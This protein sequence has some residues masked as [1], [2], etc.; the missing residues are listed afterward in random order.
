MFRNGMWIAGSLVALFVAG[1]ALTAVYAADSADGKAKVG[2]P[3]PDFTLQDQDGKDVKLSSFF[4]GEDKQQKKIVVLE[5]FNP[6]CPFVVRHYEKNTM[7]DLAAKYA[8]QGVVWIAINSTHGMG[9]ER[10]QSWIDEHE[11]PY[12]FLHDQESAVARL[13]GAKTTPHM[14]VIDRNGV[15]A[16]QGAIDSNAWAKKGDKD[17]VNYVGKA[18]DAL[19]AGETVAPAQTKAYGCSVKYPK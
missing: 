8:D 14:F 19:L 12:S 1:V 9:K 15:L 2:E 3:A 13:Y 6:D 18:V 4:Q 7:K 10:N 11:L 16:Y 5:W 17:L